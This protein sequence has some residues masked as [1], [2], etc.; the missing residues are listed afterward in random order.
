VD[1]TRGSRGRVM[2]PVDYSQPE[3]EAQ[4]KAR[5]R[6]CVRIVLFA[7]AL[8]AL[9]GAAPRQEALRDTAAPTAQLD[10]GPALRP[11]PVHSYADTRK[12]F[13]ALSHDGHRR[14][15]GSEEF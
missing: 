4:L 9:M 11:A 8:A 14:R 6:T 15:V 12:K 7:S 10:Q 5:F 13:S 1:E 3:Q 2:A